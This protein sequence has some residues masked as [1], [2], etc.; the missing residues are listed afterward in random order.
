MN[1]SNVIEILDTDLNRECIMY[2]SS[3]IMQ[4]TIQ[5]NST[6]PLT[7]NLNNETFNYINKVI[8]INDGGSIYLYLTTDLVNKNEKTEKIL[9][10]DINTLEVLT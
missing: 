7:I 1:F 4:K 6:N 3:E 9:I 2:K 8:F 10:A 5:Y